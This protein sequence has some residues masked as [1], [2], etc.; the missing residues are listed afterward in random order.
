MD[1]RVKSGLIGDALHALAP[2]PAARVAW[3]AEEKRRQK[4]RLYETFSKR[5]FLSNACSFVREQKF[6]ERAEKKS[7]TERHA[8]GDDVSDFDFSL[9]RRPSG[10][11]PGSR[12]DRAVTRGE[13]AESQIASLR[14]QLAAFDVSDSDRESGSSDADS[15]KTFAGRYVA[16]PKPPGAMSVSRPP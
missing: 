16:K 7:V 2:D 5:S 13:S 4:Q 10:A 1:R 15:P 9:V 8:N 6:G 14:A 3:V 12:R 11:E